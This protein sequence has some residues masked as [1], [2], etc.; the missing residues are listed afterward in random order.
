LNHIKH[1]VNGA[2]VGAKFTI[3][4]LRGKGWRRR[5]RREWGVSSL[6]VFVG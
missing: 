5:R 1:L 6:F 4:K 2:P 3:A